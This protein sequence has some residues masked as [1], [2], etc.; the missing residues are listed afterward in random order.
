MQERSKSLNSF[1]VLLIPPII[2]L[3]GL[4]LS[5]NPLFSLRNSGEKII[6]KFGYNLISLFVNPIG[7]VDFI[8]IIPVY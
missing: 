1:P 5:F 6:F 4:R 2:N 7:T 3:D 8:T